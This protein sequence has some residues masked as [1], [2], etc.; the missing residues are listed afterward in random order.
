MTISIR[1]VGIGA[2]TPESLSALLNE[3]RDAILALQNPQDPTP[4]FACLTAAVPD[5]AAFINCVILV[6]DIPALAY[7]DGTD[8]LRADTGAP[9]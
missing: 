7:S 1:P 8:W 3:M 4:A 6:T 2:T 9:V 5:P